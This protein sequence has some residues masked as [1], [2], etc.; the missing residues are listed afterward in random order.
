MKLLQILLGLASTPNFWLLKR[1]R[2]PT[3]IALLATKGQRAADRERGLRPPGAGVP[4]HDHRIRR[5]KYPPEQPNPSQSPTRL[6]LS[7]AG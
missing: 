4:S 1:Y 3:G 2:D 7:L 6:S 5:P